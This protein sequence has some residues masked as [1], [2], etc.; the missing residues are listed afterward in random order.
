MEKYD[1]LEIARIIGEP[2]DPRKPY[3]DIVS[4]VCE[5]DSADPNEYVYYFD[6]LFDTDYVISTIASGTTQTAVTP[7]TPSLLSFVDLAT[8]EYYVKLTDLANAKERVLGRKKITINRALN[9]IETQKVVDLLDA[10]AIA[11][12]NLNDLR[13]GETTFNYRYVVDMIDQVIDYADK[14]VLVAGSAIDKDLKLM[15]WVDSH[16]SLMSAK[17]ISAFHY[18]GGTP[19]SELREDNTEGR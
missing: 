2:K 3:S 8:N 6:V 4:A 10:A 15:D 17:T 13:S 1:H 14:Y 5:V 7:D 19:R 12:G 11:R 9:A 18:I 16:E